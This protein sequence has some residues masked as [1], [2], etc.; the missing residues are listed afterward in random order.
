M[1]F[2][3][4]FQPQYQ[5]Q[6]PQVELRAKMSQ[7]RS[8]LQGDISPI[9]QRASAMGATCTMPDG[10]KLTLE[11]LAQRMQ[12]KNPMQAFGECGYNLSEVMGIINS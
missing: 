1:G 10:S 9:V 11:Q 3:Q 6:T 2:M 12:G 4:Q 5:P 7:L 8:M